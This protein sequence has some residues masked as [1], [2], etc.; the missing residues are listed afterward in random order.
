MS[1]VVC[2]GKN[3]A[4][5]GRLSLFANLSK[6]PIGLEISYPGNN[7]VWYTLGTFRPGEMFQAAAASLLFPGDSQIRAVNHVTGDSYPL[8]KIIQSEENLFYLPENA[9]SSK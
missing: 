3:S 7:N 2:S 5:C 6:L 9:F 1:L 4:R 8:G